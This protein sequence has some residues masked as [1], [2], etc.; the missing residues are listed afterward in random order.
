ME[1][2][3]LAYLAHLGATALRQ[4]HYQPGENVCVAGLGVIGLC[5]VAVARAM[6]AR[7]IA[8][9][10]DRHRMDLARRVG[11]S[12]THLTG[13]FE[14]ASIFGGRGCDIVVLT[15][16]TWS[17]WR[18]AMESVRFG[19]RI[20]VLGFPGRAQPAPCFNPLDAR[21]LY[22]RQV[23]IQ[24][25]GHATR[26]DCEA[27]DVRFNLARSL[28]YIL[29]LMARGDLDLGPVI[30]HRIPYQRMQEAYELARRHSPE[31]S[32][33]IFE[34]LGAPWEHG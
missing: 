14:P 31:L 21:W 33:A 24:G 29:A 10:K 5:T 26:M 19:G 16:N 28:E 4:V 22:G 13:A 3:S 9:G 30:S 11:A 1:Q 23:T 32:A 12:E 17:A 18:E 20:S 25:A 2:A 6:G 15:A 8:V 27:V 7:V 34:W